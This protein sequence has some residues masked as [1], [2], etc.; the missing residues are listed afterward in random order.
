MDGREI[1]MCANTSCWLYT[2]LEGKT[3]DELLHPVT[4]TMVILIQYS[5]TVGHFVCAWLDKKVH[6]WDPFGRVDYFENLHK[7]LQQLGRAEYTKSYFFDIVRKTKLPLVFNDYT[8]QQDDWYSCGPWCLWRLTNRDMS[9]YAFYKKYK[10]KD[11]LVTHKIDQIIG[12]TRNWT[13]RN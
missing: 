8:V 7:S 10:F 11:A 3:L 5:D 4:K 1:E 13:D 6:Y 9:D 2:Q 12:G